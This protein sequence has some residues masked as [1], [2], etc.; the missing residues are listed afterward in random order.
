MRLQV[1]IS[2]QG[3]GTGQIHGRRHISAGE[4]RQAIDKTL[5]SIAGGHITAVNQDIA[6]FGQGT[7]PGLQVVAKLVEVIGGQHLVAEGDLA[8]VAMGKN[9]N[10]IYVGA[11]G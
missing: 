5:T 4:L 1:P 3:C 10:R 8:T 2:T 9:M 6:G 7:A 11:P